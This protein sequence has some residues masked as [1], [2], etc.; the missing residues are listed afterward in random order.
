MELPIRTPLLL[1]PPLFSFS[2]TCSPVASAAVL[3]SF[4][5]LGVRLCSAEVIAGAP[6]LSLVA[7]VARPGATVV[8]KFGGA[9]S[10]KP[11]SEAGYRD[12]T[13]GETVRLLGFDSV[14]CFAVA[15]T[16]VVFLTVLSTGLGC[17]F[18]FRVSGSDKAAG[19]SRKQD[20]V[21][22]MYL[23][24]P[25]GVSVRVSFA[26]REFPYWFS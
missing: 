18:A 5:T 24:V 11:G 22:D 3:R 19:T 8:I 17:G 21:T 9:S 7:D 12:F 26:P 2:L 23:Q 6:G 14:F 25:V 4:V 16:A 10:E 13:M 15:A 20:V 1:P